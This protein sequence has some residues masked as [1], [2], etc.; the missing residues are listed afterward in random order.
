MKRKK[1]AMVLSICMAGILAAGC[2]GNLN[3]GNSGDDTQ[4]APEETEGLDDSGDVNLHIWISENETTFIENVTQSFIQEHASEANITITWEEMAAGECRSNLLGDILNGPDVYT[5]TDGDLTTIVAGGG[6]SPVM[7]QDE[8]Y[9]AN[10]ESAS[11]AMMVNDTMYG[12]PFTA[13]N[14]YFLYYNKAYLSEDDIKSWDRILDVAAQNG[15]KVD[16]DWSS[17]WYIYSFFGQT[18]LSVG[19]N[20]DGIT[21]FCDWNST[22][23]AIKGVDV[24]QSLYNIGTHPGFENTGNWNEGFA[25]GS[26]IACVSGVWDAAVMQETL[27]A[28][29]GASM[30]PTYTCAGQQVQMACYFG[31][32]MLG[33]NPYSE[34][35]E[36]AHRLAEYMT[37]E[38][39]QMLHF[40][41]SG[42]GPSNAKAAESDVVNE[43]PAI[44]AVIQQS[45]YSEL[46]RLGGNFW[47]PTTELGTIMSTGNPEGRDFQEIMDTLVEG[48]TAP[49]T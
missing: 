26:V 36:W 3:L 16:M 8:V 40:E 6:A 42:Q 9:Q 24:A 20:E 11:E 34:H 18:G 45:E 21:N 29:Y 2:A 37:N 25:D 35:L 49:T 1:F 14:G 28:N 27:G 47:D 43:A 13:D 19:L 30:L 31:Y 39:N 44:K 4:N 12:Y 38:E 10:L 48:I 5:T 41:I 15:K 46:Q 32:K 23:N 7:N 33:V 17:G 22:E